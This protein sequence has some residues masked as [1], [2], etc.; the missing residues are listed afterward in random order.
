MQP[1]EERDGVTVATTRGGLVAP[2]SPNWT[3]GSQAA[4][5]NGRHTSGEMTPPRYLS[6]KTRYASY[7]PTG[8]KRNL[9]GTLAALEK[10]RTP[11]STGLSTNG[12]YWARTSDLRLVEA[13]LSQLS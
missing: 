2:A 3:K 12:R 6:D 4:P 7:T 10:V 13:A 11:M 8:H 1:G 5:R 9:I